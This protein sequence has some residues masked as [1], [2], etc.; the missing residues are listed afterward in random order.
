MLPLFKHQVAAADF[1][2]AHGGTGALFMDMGTGKTRTAIEIFRQLRE[3]VDVD[4]SLRVHRGNE[5][6]IKMVV[7]APLSLLEAAWGEDIKCFSAFTYYNAHDKTLPMSTIDG[8]CAFREDILLINYEAIIQP[9]NKH[10]Q[11]HIMNSLLVLDESS[12]MKSPNTQTTKMLLS[13]AELAK[14]KVIMSGTPAPNSPMEY[15]PQMDFLSPGIL[16]TSFSQF[17]NTFFYLSRGNQMIMEQGKVNPQFV[18]QMINQKRIN[19]AEGNLLLRGIITRG[20]ASKIF[21]VGAEYRISDQNLGHLMDKIKPFVFWAKKE[22]CLDLPEQIDEVR[23]V[24]LTVQQ[25]KHYK[26]MEHDLITE[27]KNCAVTAPVALTKIMK[28]REITSGFAIDVEGHEVD[29]EPGVPIKI[30]ELETV[31]EEAGPRQVIIWGCFK[32]DIR[33]ICSFLA[34]KYG[35]DCARTLYSGTSDHLASIEEFKAGKARFLVAN[36]ASAA[37]GLTFVNCDLQV[38]FSLDYSWERYV[39]A[40]A[41]IHRAGQINKCTYVHLIA[42][43]TIDEEVLACLR[44]KGDIN[45]VAYGLISK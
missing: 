11:Y 14:F 7:I 20:L 24:D 23:M 18:V 1:I 28:L 15:F 16:G 25:A 37:H 2:V 33:R 21:S 45:K 32:W 17:R 6:G 39:Q 3:T 9:K 36:P 27:I 34:S 31:L 38:F 13:F 19:A 26:E 12:R 40:K 41:R 5:P 4:S 22:N 29:I 30:R 43:D 8:R 10:L 44:E 35:T 42:R